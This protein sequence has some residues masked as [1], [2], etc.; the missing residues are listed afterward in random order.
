MLL[1]STPNAVSLVDRVYGAKSDTV[2]SMTYVKSDTKSPLKIALQVRMLNAN[3]VIRESSHYKR[4]QDRNSFTALHFRNRNDVLVLQR[5]GICAG[6]NLFSRFSASLKENAE[7][8]GC[9]EGRRAD[10]KNVIV[11][12]KFTDWDL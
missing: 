6:G 10:L 5:Y 9:R 8:S 4:S 7:S 1:R 12:M 11:T 3:G 2:A